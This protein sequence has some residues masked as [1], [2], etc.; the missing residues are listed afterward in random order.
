MP[1]IPVP[2]VPSKAQI[3]LAI[4]LTQSGPSQEGTILL[5]RNQPTAKSKILKMG[6]AAN[7][8]F[9]LVDI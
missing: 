9:G 4:G 6:V 7:E 1:L 5:S 2:M 3:D 8:G